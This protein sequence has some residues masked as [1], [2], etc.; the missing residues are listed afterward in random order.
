MA[1]YQACFRTNYFWVKDQ[2][3]FLDW[4][5]TLPGIEAHRKTPSAEDSAFALFANDGP[6]SFDT[7]DN[8]VHFSTDLAPHLAD[9]EVA[10]L[11]EIGH[12]K[13]RYL[14]GQATAIHP[15]GRSIAISLD[16]I[17]RTAQDTFGIQAPRAEY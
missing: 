9:N 16:D 13:L 10:I 6:P 12:E 2:T 11:L 3:A 17:Y 4:V 15:S 8:E 1:D 14:V 5:A 7:S